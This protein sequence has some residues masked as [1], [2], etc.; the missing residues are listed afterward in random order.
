MDALVSQET[1]FLPAVA[2]R[3]GEIFYQQLKSPDGTTRSIAVSDI[4]VNKEYVP[5]L[6]LVLVAFTQSI[7]EQLLRS[8]SEQFK[9][10]DA[11]IIE[12]WMAPEQVTSGGKVTPYWSYYPYEF[13]RNKLID[14]FL[15]WRGPNGEHVAYRGLHVEAD[16]HAAKLTFTFLATFEW[17]RTDRST[18]N[19]IVDEIGFRMCTPQGCIPD[20]E[21]PEQDDERCDPCK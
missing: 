11:F 15:D 6:P 7:G 10:T 19:D 20:P 12:F 21:C 3:V 2:A 18:A 5:T 17:C 9:I 16:H 13:I 4:D 14:G 1:R 8:H